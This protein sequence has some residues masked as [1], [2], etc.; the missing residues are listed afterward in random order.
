MCF[1]PKNEKKNNNKEKKKKQ[2]RIQIIMQNKIMQGMRMHA[3]RVQAWI[4]ILGIGVRDNN[5][6]EWKLQIFG[7]YCEFVTKTM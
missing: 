1:V 2:T 4:E 7:Q 5:K 3:I 6:L